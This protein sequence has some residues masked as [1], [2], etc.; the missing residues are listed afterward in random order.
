MVEKATAEVLKGLED[1]LVIDVRDP[2]EVAEGKGGPPSAI[3]GSVNVPLNVD[4][5]KQNLQST[6]VEQDAVLQLQQRILELE[7]RLGPAHGSA[8]LQATP[9]AAG[10]QLLAAPHQSADPQVLQRLRALAGS[11]PGRFGAHERALRAERP[12]VALDN[13][14]QEELLGATEEDELQEALNTALEEVQDP[15]QRLLVLQTQQLNMLSGS[16]QKALG[17]SDSSGSS[18][19]G[20][21][22][23]LAR[24]AFLK[25]SQD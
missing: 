2:N 25:V 19:G 23:C 15:M 12:E 11:G 13:A 14:L 22:G 1:P 9:K 3:P 10:P 24:E 17:G 16:H 6:A 7:S 18:G 5:K 21:R 8:A 20:V 4:G